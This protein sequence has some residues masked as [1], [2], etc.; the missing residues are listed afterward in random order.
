MFSSPRYRRMLAIAAVGLAAALG[1]CVAYPGYYG[2]GYGYGYAP[3]YA[4][5]YGYAPAYV[6]YGWGGW[7]RH[8]HDWDRR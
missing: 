7:Y 5:N 4:Y 8:D 1:G 3:A 6:G 2:N